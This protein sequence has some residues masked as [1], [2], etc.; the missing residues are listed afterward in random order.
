MES[1]QTNPEDEFD[2]RP[3]L[4][5]EE[6]SE[7]AA[8][9]GLDPE[10]VRKAALHLYADPVNANTS[11]VSDQD[12]V[13]AERWIEGDLTEEFVDLVISDLNHRYNTTH[14]KESLRDNILGDSSSKPKQ[15]SSIQRTD[16]SLEWTYSNEDNSVIVRALIQSRGDQIRIRISKKELQDAGYSALTYDDPIQYMSYVPYLAGIVVLFSLPFSFFVNLIAAIILFSLLRI[17]LIPGAKKLSMWF[18]EPDLQKKENPIK[19]YKREVELVSDD[20]AKLISGKET[21]TQEKPARIEFPDSE[22]RREDSETRTGESRE[23][24]RG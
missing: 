22:K 5:L 19:K 12:E 20:L 24:D 8:E 9:A 4:S 6:L 10:N 16:N 2:S 3:G 13:Y 23:R 11:T 15:R 21:Q 14:K 18:G 1:K 17:S 7:V